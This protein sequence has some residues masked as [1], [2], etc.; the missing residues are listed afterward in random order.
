MQRVPPPLQGSHV[1]VDGQPVASLSLSDLNGPPQASAFTST[2]DPSSILA[3]RRSPQASGTPL[4]AGSSA[5]AGAS[6]SSSRT[7]SSGGCPLSP[8]RSA[9]LTCSAAAQSE[10]L[11]SRQVEGAISTLDESIEPLEGSFEAASQPSSG[12][13]GGGGLSPSHA[14]LWATRFPFILA[15]PQALIE[16]MLLRCLEREY[17]CTVE[18]GAR[19]VALSQVGG[20]NSRGE[21]G[22]TCGSQAQALELCMGK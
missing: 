3:A 5:S 7:H 6:G 20:G 12:S 14:S 10:D 9:P 18:W 17:G 19:L 11:H 22:A 1:C 2:T 21:G 16:L 4:S 15:V 8:Q 13:G